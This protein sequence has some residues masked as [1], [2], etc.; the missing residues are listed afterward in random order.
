MLGI[1]LFTLLPFINQKKR[2]R[3]EIQKAVITI[4]IVLAIIAAV[5]L[6]NVHYFVA[7]MFGF[8]AMIVFDR[9]T[10]TK[11]RLLIYVPIALVVGGALYAMLRDN[12][13]YVLQH[14]EE[15][16]AST[17][18]YLAENGEV[19]VGY[20]AD[21]KRPLASMVKIVIALQY[22]MALENNELSRETRVSLDE[23]ANFYL[24]NSDGGAHEEWLAAMDAAGAI[25]DNTVSLHDVAKGM[26]TYSSN[27]NTDYLI[28]LLGAEAI[29]ARIADIGLTEHDDV[30]PIVAALYMSDVVTKDGMSEEQVIQALRDMPIED[31]GDAAFQLSADM[32]TGALNLQNETLQLSSKLQKVWSDR[33]IGATAREYGKLLRLISSDALPPTAAEAMRNLMEWPMELNKDNEAHYA[34]LGAKG[35]STMFILNNALYSEDLEGN[36]FEL[37][38]FTNNLNWL[39]MLLLQKNRNSFEA[40]VLNDAAFRQ[41][42]VA[43]LTND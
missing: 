7:L 5:L 36:Q 11:K 21:V 16:R 35:G 22:A 26:V 38:Y 24:Q 31:Y 6:F 28:H 42:V 19:L 32:Q 13:E 34:H 12:P 27:A 17:S 43:A 14:I 29:N 30:Y 20:E 1:I 18:L 10:Y 3:E 15:H 2:T 39:D 41:K 40:H 9:K 4:G 25:K 8:V 37:V 33:L 23:L